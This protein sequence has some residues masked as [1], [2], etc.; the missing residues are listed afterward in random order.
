MCGEVECWLC[1]E[2]RGMCVGSKREVMEQSKCEVDCKEKW[3]CLHEVSYFTISRP[4]CDWRQSCEW[5]I[6]R[7]DTHCFPVSSGKTQGE[8]VT[9]DSLLFWNYTQFTRD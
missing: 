8:S 2:V 5:G 1:G 6:G 7:T 9:P 3:V 4:K